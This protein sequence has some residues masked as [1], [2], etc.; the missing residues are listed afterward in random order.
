MRFKGTY[1]RVGYSYPKSVI[2]GDYLYISYA[3]NKEDVELTRIPIA[4][5]LYN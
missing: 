2:W 1:K 3:T 5:L 4:S